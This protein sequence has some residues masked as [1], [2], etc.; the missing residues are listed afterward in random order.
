MFHRRRPAA[1]L[2]SAIVA[3][4]LSSAFLGQ[5]ACSSGSSGGATSATSA[6]AVAPP[7]VTPTVRLYLMS[8]VAGAL[9]PCGCSKDQ[10]GGADRFAA[11]LAA[12]RARVPNRLLLGAG[13][14]FFQEPV[15]SS[16][17][18]QQ[19][20]WKAD[21]LADAMKRMGLVA[22]APGA[23][24]FAAGREAFERLRAA[25][26]ASFVG[27][28][29]ALEGVVPSTIVDVGGISIGIVGLSD[30][31][32]GQ[33]ELLAKRRAELAAAGAPPKGTAAASASPS[34]S[35]TTPAPKQA[36]TAPST[37]LDLLAQVGV[38]VAPPKEAL[39]AEVE[40][41]RRKGARVVV[42]LFAMP[43]GEALR[44]LDDYTELDV[45][46]IGK[47]SEK[48]DGNDAPKPA[49]LVEN[50]VVVET[51]NHLQTVAVLDLFV[52][53]PAENQGRVR[54]ADAGGVARAEQFTSLAA[55]IRDLETRITGWEQGRTISP[56]DLGAR[57]ADLERLRQE[58]R[59]LEAEQSPPPS[60]SYFVYSLVEI[61]GSLGKD[62]DVASSILSFRKRVNEHNKVAFRDR[63]PEPAPEGTASYLG[64][65]ACSDCHRD[66]RAVWDKTQ[67]ARAYATLEKEH[68]EFNLECVGCHVTGYDRPGGSTVTHVE[69]LKDVGCEV[70]HG[71]GSRH[72]ADP[73]DK[74][75]IVRKPE[76]KSCVS[77]CHHPPHVENFDPVA[78]MQ[79]VLGPGHGR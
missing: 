65:E 61:R 41:L 56:A 70:C 49:V 8:T 14:L 75:L 54:F 2:G 15:L 79:L 46:V 78:K 3:A 62:A 64:V 69:K 71:P 18:R 23:N 73:A 74:S 53:E 20:E 24:D 42:G 57:R 21:A 68:V 52:R 32:A 29:L 50:T 47:A 72:A 5:S 34:A 51:S 22:W 77:E 37:S 43:R 66:E 55:R 25:T 76:P 44:L 16:D 58:R 59:A 39:Q 67:H 38:E 35:P 26:G 63:T 30:P 13:P 28:N 33:R 19:D 27:A 40:A 45:V 48:G 31:T 6:Q 60:G 36:P 11:Q 4:A 1:L 7:S 17:L 12:D 10:L 9:V